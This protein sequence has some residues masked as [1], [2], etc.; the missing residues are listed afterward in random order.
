MRELFTITVSVEKPI[1]VG[2]DG[3]NGRRQLI[4]I[5]TG[6]LEGTDI[7][8]NP[9]KGAVLPGGVDS[10]VIRPDGKCELSARYAV[11][12]DDGASFYIEN[13]GMR[14]VPDEYVPQVLR[15]E[16]IDPALYY[17]ATVPSFEAY[18]DSLRW[19]ENHVF[20]CRAVREPDTVRI[21]YW[22]ID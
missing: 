5:G 2:Q 1:V 8:G 10:Q 11:R 4:P 20:F 18:S 6:T 7:Y 16:F 14:T 13:N 15:G 9:L 21:V 22:I 17:F 12:L 19:L 3:K